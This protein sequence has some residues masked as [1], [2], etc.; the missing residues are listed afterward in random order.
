MALDH[1]LLGLLTQCITQFSDGGF[2]GVGCTLR[3][4]LEWAWKKVAAIKESI[5]CRGKLWFLDG[6]IDTEPV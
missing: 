3:S 4:I 6:L 2:N 5:D 1:H